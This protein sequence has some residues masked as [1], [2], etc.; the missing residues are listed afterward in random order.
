MN[1]KE[2][3]QEHGVCSE[4]GRCKCCDKPPQIVYQYVTYPPF[5]VYPYYPYPIPMYGTPVPYVGP[6]AIG[7]G[8]N[9][10]ITNTDLPTMTFTGGSAISG[11]SFC[12]DSMNIGSPTS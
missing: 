12:I 5:Y 6:A 11:S 10:N 9:M 3:K 4:C 2:K 7:I 1:K 8:G